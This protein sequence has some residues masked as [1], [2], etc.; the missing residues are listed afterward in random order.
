MPDLATLRTGPSEED[1]RGSNGDSPSG[2]G[3]TGGAT[4]STLNFED[5]GATWTT[6]HGEATIDEAGE[7]SQEFSPRTPDE[8]SPPAGA[9]PVR[10]DA[11]LPNDLWASRMGF[12]EPEH[13]ESSSPK[14][15]P[16][17]PRISSLS[18]AA[19]RGEQTP[20]TETPDPG[21]RPGSSH[22]TDP[23]GAPRQAQSPEVLTGP[24][25]SVAADPPRGG[26]VKGLSAQWTV[27]DFLGDGALGSVWVGTEQSTRGRIVARTIP[28]P[29]SGLSPA[30]AQE[31]DRLR[32]IPAKP[33]VVCHLGFDQDI[34]LGS[35]RREFVLYSQHV[36]GR[37]VRDLLDVAPGGVMPIRE[38]SRHLQGM[39]RGLEHLHAN[40]VVH[41]CLRSSV[42]LIAQDGEAWL[43]DPG[44]APLV[45]RA[46]LRPYKPWLAPEVLTGGPLT[47][48]A[49]VWSVGCVV[50]E[51]CSGQPPVQLE[52]TVDQVLA[53]LAKDSF[54]NKIAGDLEQKAKMTGQHD[55][56][57]AVRP[58]VDAC[59]NPEAFERPTPTELSSMIRQS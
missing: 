45:P 3:F 10:L 18:T 58:F 35:R 46:R 56:P 59:L 48:Q 32:K 33:N 24:G 29:S 51:M 7:F 14:A 43:V 21:S 55:L 50:V 47:P 34:Y 5:G 31:A 39:L 16:G 30:I 52:N 44:V 6:L 26:L 49:D 41:G 20:R 40:R 15:P 27:E 19:P 17:M 12:V 11:S 22:S 54:G 36:S 42:I 4:W 1:E 9:L 2:L 53:Q 25:G 57:R 37:S 38:V 28:L 23:A 8:G 13:R